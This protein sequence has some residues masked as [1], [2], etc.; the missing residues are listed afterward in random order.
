VIL[1]LSL[2]KTLLPDPVPALQGLEPISE[3]RQ[4]TRVPP[5]RPRRL[6]RKLWCGSRSP[7]LNKKCLLQ[8]LHQEFGKGSRSSDQKGILI[9]STFFY[10]SSINPTSSM[11]SAPRYPFGL[12][13][14]EHSTRERVSKA[15]QAPESFCWKNLPRGAESP[16]IKGHQYS[17]WCHK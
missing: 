12:S 10:C 17:N 2:A 13:C 6:P 9:L 11:Q 5:K 15:V 14:K 4:T 16:V 3:R 7:V 8:L 1:V